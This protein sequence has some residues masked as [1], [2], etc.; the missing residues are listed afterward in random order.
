MNPQYINIS[1]YKFVPIDDPAAVKAD[2]LPK[3]KALELKG[4]ILVSLEGINMFVAG[5]RAAIDELA[6][7]SRLAG[8]W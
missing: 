2:L 7:I 1:A 8:C 6:I 4:T 5:T 3:C